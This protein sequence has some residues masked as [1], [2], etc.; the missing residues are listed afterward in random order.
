[1]ETILF[2]DFLVT[3]PKNTAQSEIAGCFKDEID[4]Y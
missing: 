2:S 4:D 1:M 3:A